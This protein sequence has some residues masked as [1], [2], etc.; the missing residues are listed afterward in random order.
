MAYFDTKK[1]PIIEETVKLDRKENIITKEMD[2][3][4]KQEK[5][6]VKIT[7]NLDTEEKTKTKETNPQ[8]QEKLLD[9]IV[10]EP[11]PKSTYKIPKSPEGKIIVKN[12][13]S[14]L[15][16]TEGKASR[17]LKFD[18]YSKSKNEEASSTEVK[19]EIIVKQK[20][21]SSLKYVNLNE[22]FSGSK[23]SSS[24]ERKV[25]KLNYK[26]HRQSSIL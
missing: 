4:T 20:L 19:K 6:L 7:G 25:G 12:S 11:E 17:I 22:G 5:T 9:K 14:E 8:F 21:H 16:Q 1:N 13:H 26:S 18:K 24:K 15:K 2:I 23:S 3:I 10:P